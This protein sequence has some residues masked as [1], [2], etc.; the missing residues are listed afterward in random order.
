MQNEVDQY[1]VK[2]SSY[3]CGA[4]GDF[5]FR[6]SEV[7]PTCCQFPD[8]FLMVKLSGYKWVPDKESMNI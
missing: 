1:C 2:L 7:L 3:K 5:H 8:C 4:F 6:G